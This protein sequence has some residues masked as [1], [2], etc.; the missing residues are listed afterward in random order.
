MVSYF[1]S[2]VGKEKSKTRR[3]KLPQK[4][5]NFENDKTRFA[6][7]KVSL[8]QKFLVFWY[9]ICIQGVEQESHCSKS[10]GIQQIF[11]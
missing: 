8:P 3:G 4:V 11:H 10:F 5:T 1:V 2:G 7:E 9:K 6:A